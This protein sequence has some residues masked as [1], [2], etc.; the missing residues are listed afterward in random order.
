MGQQ[1]SASSQSGAIPLGAQPNVPPSMVAQLVCPIGPTQGGKLVEVPSQTVTAS[2]QTAL[3]VNELGPALTGVLNVTVVSGTNPT[4]DV[5]LQVSFDG[6]ATWRDLYHFERQTA[7]TGGFGKG[8]TIMPDLI[9]SGLRRW[10]WT[11]GGTNPS[12]TFSIATTGSGAEPVPLRQFYDYTPSLLSGVAFAISATYAVHSFENLYLFVTL[13][14]ATTAAKYQIQ[15]SL[16]GTNWAFD[17]NLQGV[18]NSTAIGKAVNGGHYIRI[19]CSG[20][21]VA[22]TGVAIGIFGF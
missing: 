17:S 5:K 4:L 7:A 11:V 2:G 19:A 9:V 8:T 20:A 21:G 15:L 3:I 18:A 1:S 13:G 12:F 16:D 10:V 6:G 14:A 22:Q